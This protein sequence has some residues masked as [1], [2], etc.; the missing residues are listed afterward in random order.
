MILTI[1]EIRIILRELGGGYSEKPEI[2]RKM[3]EEV[4]PPPRLEL[5]S[6]K[7]VEGWVTWGNQIMDR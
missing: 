7:E 1:E 2:V 5:F 6:R 3:I 4:S